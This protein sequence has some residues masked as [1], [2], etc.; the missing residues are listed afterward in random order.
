VT[1]EHLKRG[2]ACNAAVQAFEKAF[3]NGGTWPDD[4]AKAE[5]AGLDVNWCR[6][7]GLLRPVTEGG[8]HE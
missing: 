7:F 5:A 3:P 1:A 2:N 4:I 8:S 6:K